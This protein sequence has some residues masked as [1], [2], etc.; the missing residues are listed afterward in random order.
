VEIN[1]VVPQKISSASKSSYTISV[2][3]PK[4]YSPILHGHSLHYVH[5]SF[6]CNNQKWETTQM[7]LNR[8]IDKI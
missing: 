1:L 5:S 7:P 3:K 4:R 2:Y 8:R 6:I